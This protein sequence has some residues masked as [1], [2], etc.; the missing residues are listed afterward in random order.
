MVDKGICGRRS[1]YLVRERVLTKVSGGV[2]CIMGL[3]LKS[4]LAIE[5]QWWLCF[6]AEPK[7]GRLRSYQ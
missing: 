6:L 3:E 4:S 5:P 7:N 2:I 1:L